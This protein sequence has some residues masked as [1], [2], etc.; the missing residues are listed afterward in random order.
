[1][2]VGDIEV[3]PVLDAV[4]VFGELREFYPDVPPE[5]WAPY[6]DTYPELFADDSW[7]PT[8][9]AYLVRSAGRILLVDTGIGPPG[10]W[11]DFTPEREGLLPSGLS[12]LGVDRSDVDLV[13][14]THMHIDHIG[15]NADAEG[16]PFF[17]AARYIAHADAIDSALS[18]SDRPHIQRCLLSL[19]DRLEPVRGETE[20]APGVAAFETPGHYPG[21]M[22]VRI[23][24]G[25]AAAVILGDVAPHPALL[26][27]PDSVFAFDD[28]PLEN[29]RVRRRLLDELRDPGTLAICGHYPGGGIGRIV[30]RDDRTAWVPVR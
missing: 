24:S 16:A 11:E 20:L 27:Q 4:G 21:H 29:A 30:T 8:C 22:A 12:E 19:G 3:A 13:F 28:D 6:R 15:W 9:H 7:R 10:V 5:A 23:G 14:L 2:L 17:P 26:D 25:D 18:Q 1:M